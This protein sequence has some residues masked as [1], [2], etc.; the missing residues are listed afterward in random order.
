MTIAAHNPERKTKEYEQRWW[1][2]LF[3]G[4]SLL[5]IS[6]DNTIL[7]VAI[8]S[9]SR[10]LNATL[11][12]L[13]WIVD[14]YVLVFAA[15]LLTMGGLGD[16]FGR[17]KALQVG[18]ILFGI[19]SLAAAL[20]PSTGALI[21]ARAFLGIGGATI[22]PATLSIISAT[23]PSNERP[24]AIALWAAVFGLGVGLGPLIGGWLLERFEWNS[25]FFVNLPVIVIALIG[26]AVTLAD[27]R[28]E[29][30]PK[31]DLPGVILSIAGLFSLIY[32]IIDAGQSGWDH[33]NV[34]MAFVAAAVLLTIF[35][36]WENRNP[37]A[38]LPMHFFKNMSFTGANVAL[39]FVTFSMF[40][41]VF[42]LSQY[43]QTVQGY[44]TFDAGIRVLP[45]ALMLA[46]A[47]AQ[48]S[49]VAARLGTKYT[50][51]LGIL[52]AAGGL[53]FMGTQYQIDSPYSTILIGQLILAIGLGSSI[54]PATNSIMQ[55]VPVSKAGI[56]SAMNDTTR[57]LGGALGIA[58]LGTI[59]NNTYI[60]G[61]ENLRSSI[62]IPPALSALADQA[63]EAISSGIQAAH[64]VAGRLATNPLVPADAAQT[65]IDTANHAF[66]DG[67]HNAL[68]IGA[69]IMFFS[70][71]FALVVLPNEVR[72][73]EDVSIPEQTGNVRLA[74]SGD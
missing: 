67:M 43:L 46:F 60:Q 6:L 41:S 9:I 21:A 56:G 68:L 74:V 25:V 62:A 69:V 71:I 15:L 52:I 59:M 28:D 1:G 53:L 61:V 44:S 73:M 20:A 24:R 10:T 17:K 49:R 5:V 34:V 57:Q 13:Q 29:H 36:W 30:A 27:S 11:S 35:V 47:A 65:I 37:N 51:T 22:M 48:S 4:I 40:G 45:M 3:I 38:M 2:L 31:T 66:V 39:A 32:G 55:A 64:I 16:R 58:V 42:F 19:G 8:P 50:V 23:F 72:R 54:S 12:E 7:N 70:A 14:A 33:P 18:L 63:F 26:G